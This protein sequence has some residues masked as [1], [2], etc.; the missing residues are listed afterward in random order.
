MRA[1]YPK[2]NPKPNPNPTPNP[3]L[4]QACDRVHRVGQVHPVHVVRFVAAGTVEEKIL[5][6]Q[7]R[8]QLL[9]SSALG[10]A[11]SNAAAAGTG[12]SSKDEARRLRLADLRLCFEKASTTEGP[13][14]VP[15]QG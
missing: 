4:N 12:G 14:I 10:G 7:R 13:V 9:C 3:N 2:P 15:G 11:D 8:K 1:A 5:E 6:L